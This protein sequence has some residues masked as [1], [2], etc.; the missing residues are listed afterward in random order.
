MKVLFITEMGFSGKI[1]RTH[2]NMRTEFAWMCALN[3]DHIPLLHILS[4]NY[5]PNQKYD[6]CI[7]ILP[8][9]IENYKNIS[10]LSDK[11]KYISKKWG[12]MQEGPHWYFQDYTYINQ[13]HYINILSSSDFIF[14]HNIHDIKYF[15]GLFPKKYITNLKSLMIEDLISSHQEKIPNQESTTIIG[16]NFCSW[17]S[18]FDS[19]IIAQEFNTKVFAPS[20]GRIIE[21]ENQMENLY[22]LPYMNWLEWIH[23]LSSFKYAVHLM[24]IHAAG[25]FSLNCAYLGIPCIGY[26]GLDT[27]EIL[28]PSLS[29]EVGNLQAAKKLAKL[30]STDNDFYIYC[31][32]E[33]TDM[34]KKEYSESN[35]VLDFSKKYQKMP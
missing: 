28:H 33:C 9:K 26:Y 27:Q 31:A 22:H 1:P 4:D 2:T 30:L 19:Y 12:I 35:W 24:R 6:I 32:K 25:T 13:I 29:V 5:T 20:M 10:H 16:G 17:Y 21:H 8:K 7:I 34:Y 18:G 23:T 14:V 15:S 3:A 11:V